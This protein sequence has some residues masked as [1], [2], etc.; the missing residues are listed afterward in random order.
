MKQR[1]I[2]GELAPDSAGIGAPPGLLLQAQNVRPY[3]GKYLPVPALQAFDLIGTLT[4]CIGLGSF[5]AIAGLY[6]GQVVTFAGTAAKL[7]YFSGASLGFVDR[8]RAVGGAY[9][10]T[11]DAHWEFEQMGDFVIAAGAGEIPQFW[12]LSADPESAGTLWDDIPNAPGYTGAIPD[13]EHIA[14]CRGFLLGSLDFTLTWSGFGD[15]AAWVPDP[16]GTQSDF[17]VFQTGGRVQRIIGGE[18]AVVVQERAIQRMTYI[19]VPDIFQIDEVATNTGTF[20]PGSVVKIGGLIYFLNDDGFQ[21]FNGA[22]VQTIGDGK[23]N[24]Y[25]L[26]L[27]KQEY[28]GRMSAAVDPVNKLIMWAAVSVNNSAGDPTPDIIICYHYTQD[29][30]TTIDVGEAIDFLASAFTYPFTLDQIGTL[31]GSIEDVSPPLDDTFWQGSQRFPALVNAAHKLSYLQGSPLPA[32]WETSELNPG[33]DRRTV[34]NKVWPL[35]DGGASLAAVGSRD[36]Q[37]GAVVYD[38]AAAVNDTGFV[39]VRHAGRYHSLKITT[40]AGTEFESAIGADLEYS[41]GG[42]R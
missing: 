17:Q 42:M 6:A 14:I 29:R 8:S 40:E 36:L 39:P 26:N 35:V 2:F 34:V 37:S 32:T 13:F 1:I 5:K 30:W 11:G 16:L 23:I 3:G 41:G 7:N 38:A 24:R 9:A 25:F 18:Y 20:A 31:F 4:R 15:F 12:D 28:L 27:V 19:G 22:Q 10:I 33:G 21:V